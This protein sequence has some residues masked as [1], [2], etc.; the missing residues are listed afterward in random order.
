MNVEDQ[1]VTGALSRLILDANDRGLSYGKMAGQAVDP[2]TGTTVSKPYLQRLAANPPANP[3]NLPQIRAL[4]AALRISE[5]RIKAAAAE[6]W[7]DYKT[8]EP[9]SYT[10][11]MRAI[12]DLLTGMPDPELSRWRAMIQAV[13]ELPDLKSAQPDNAARER[14][15]F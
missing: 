13:R 14:S 10:R 6:Q 15:S 7:L 1:P 3:P 9:G 2:E 11:E 4:A 8:A 5:R 12:V